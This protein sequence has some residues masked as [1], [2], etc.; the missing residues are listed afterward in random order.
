MISLLLDVIVC[1][2]IYWVC[3][4]FVPQP[5]LKIILVIL[6]IIAVLAVLSSF[7]VVS[8]IPLLR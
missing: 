1:G 3:S 8:G 2:V 5:F 4:L 7:G 6:V